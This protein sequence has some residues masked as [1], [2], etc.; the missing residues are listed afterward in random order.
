MD[1]N[2]LEKFENKIDITQSNINEISNSLNLLNYKMIEF[3]E[4]TKEMNQARIDG[5]DYSKEEIE[6][7][8][9]ELNILSNSLIEFKNKVKSNTE[10]RVM[11]HKIYWLF[12]TSVI[13]ITL[14]IIKEKMIK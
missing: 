3:L 10:S 5:D 12:F 14:L 8:K 2:K 4:K 7:I 11:L 6:K 9:K 13:G 1:E